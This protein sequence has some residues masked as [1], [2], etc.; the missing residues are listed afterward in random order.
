MRD[1]LAQDLAANFDLALH[2][3]QAPG[4]AR[5]RL[6]SVGLNVRAEPDALP[7]QYSAL[8]EGAPVA[9][10]STLPLAAWSSRL[11]DAGIPAQVSHHAGTYLCNATLYW[12]LHLAKEM[13]LRTEATFVHLPLE[14]S[15]VLVSRPDRPSMP[16]SQMAAALRLLLAEFTARAS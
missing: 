5:V 11:R 1:R 9:Y 12:S 8:S 15:Q 7:D 3:G 4:A 14:T 13:G 10:R 6:E 2:L 16:A